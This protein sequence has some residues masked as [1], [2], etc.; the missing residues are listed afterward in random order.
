MD[1]YM[2]GFPKGIDWDVVLHRI[3]IEVACGKRLTKNMLFGLFY[4][5]DYSLN[6][7]ENKNSKI[8]FFESYNGRAN[9][10]D[11]LKT[12]ASLVPSDVII[13]KR[14]KRELAILSGL[15]YTFAYIPFWMRTLNKMFRGNKDIKRL[16]LYYLV[17]THRFY[18]ELDPFLKKRQEG[19]Y[20]LFVAFYDS[21]TK[22]AFL[23]Q[24]MKLQ[25][26]T[27]ATLQHGAFTAQ[28]NNQL[29]NSGVELKTINSD[30]FLC[31][32]KFTVD[33]ALKEGVDANKCIITGIVGFAKYDNRITCKEINNGMFGVVIGHPTFEKENVLLIESA[34]ILAK[35]KGLKYYLKLHPAY[36]ED[37]FN[38][39]VNHDYYVGNVKKGIPMLDY[40]NSVEFSIVGASSVFIEMV[41]LNHKVIRYSSGEIVDKWRDIKLGNYYSKSVDIVNAYE[42]MCSNKSDEELFDYLCTVEDVKSSY[43]S[44]FEKYNTSK[45]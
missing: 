20:N 21:M 13:E 1:I 16:S 42:L 3:A 5:T 19:A 27:T 37:Y 18:K 2:K 44:F 24:L 29:V 11:Y 23:A 34:N 32:N 39:L 8:L 4:H 41:Y 45:T 38:E 30:Y 7:Q 26:V 17:G 28:R 22:E 6:F 35:A 40:A 14:G 12:I 15:K 31:W 43:R 25:G 36:K 9:F 10:V 33:E